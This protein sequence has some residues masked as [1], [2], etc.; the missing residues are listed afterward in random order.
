MAAEKLTVFCAGR[1]FLTVSR[2]NRVADS[3]PLK[4]VAATARPDPGRQVDQEGTIT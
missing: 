4:D 3:P 2:L 1:R